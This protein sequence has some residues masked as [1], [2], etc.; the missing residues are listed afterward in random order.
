VGW[1]GAVVILSST[2][3]ERR[4]VAEMS[5]D[6]ERVYGRQPEI[7]STPASGGVKREPVS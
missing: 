3:R 6:F 5:A 1:G 4:V 2:E 7:W